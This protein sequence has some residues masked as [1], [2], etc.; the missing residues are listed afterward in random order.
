MKVAIVGYGM[1]GARIAR[2]LGRRGAEVTVFGAEPSAAYNRI[3]LS[4]MIAGKQSEDEIALP[5]PPDHVEL[6]LGIPVESIDLEAK[7]VDGTAFDK[8]VLATGAEAFVPRSPA[9]IRCRPAPTC[10][11]RSRT[12][13][14]S[15]PRPRTAPARSSSAGAC[16]AWR[17]R[18]ASPG[19]AW[20]SPSYTPEPT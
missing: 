18:A 6:R 15:W 14:R 9:S 4:S 10:C 1:A 16:S 5:T 3:L 17:P 11:G 2:E 8:L 7:T 13:A 20:T 19:A 12:P